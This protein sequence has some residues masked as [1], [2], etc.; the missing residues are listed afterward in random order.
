M[1]I[2][3]TDEQL[4]LEL[5]TSL[6]LDDVRM[7]CEKL[8][9]SETFI[10][11]HFIGNERIPEKIFKTIFSKQPLSKGFLV[12]HRDLYNDKWLM[13]NPYLKNNKELFEDLKLIDKLTNNQKDGV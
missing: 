4:E 12:K 2:E 10:E 7:L 3:K 5:K 13:V 11:K 8:K 9:L 6:F 1:L